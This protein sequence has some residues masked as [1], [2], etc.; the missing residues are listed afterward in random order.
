MNN[1][2]LT[3]SK[4]FWGALIAFIPALWTF[5]TSI[6]PEWKIVSEEEVGDTVAALFTAAG[7]A[8]AIYGRL[9]A[10]TVIGKLEST[11]ETPKE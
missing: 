9:K 2:S 8:L 6:V 3:K 4:T 7:A 11:A 5:V 10:V 1:K